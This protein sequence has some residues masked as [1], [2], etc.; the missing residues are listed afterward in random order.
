MGP[1]T[2]A[3]VQSLAALGGLVY[4]R[5]QAAGLHGPVRLIKL[6]PALLWCL[7]L[8][9][10]P[11]LAVGYL[12]YA[13]GD[14]FLLDKG[15]WFLAGLGAFLIGHGFVIAGRLAGGTP[16]AAALGLGGGLAV[17]MTGLLWPALRGPLRVGVPVYA[18]TLAL[19]VWAATARSPIGTAGAVLFLTSD[20]IL[21]WN[22]FRAPLRHSDVAVM[23]T[24]YLAI[25]LIATG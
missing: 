7:T 5:V 24:Y 18:A 16:Q 23:V 13:L 19:L 2:V 4:L 17:A 3:V 15:R 1:A 6:A 25:A 20:L 22:R 9:D 8:G 12:G 21:A 10:R 14:L 11:L